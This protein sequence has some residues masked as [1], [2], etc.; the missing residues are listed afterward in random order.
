MEYLS[1][2]SLRN[3]WLRT[4]RNIQIG[5]MVTIQDDNLPAGKW[6]VGRVVEVHPGTDG[7]VRVVTLKTKNGYI[8]RPVVKLS[9]LPIQKEED[10]KQH[11]SEEGVQKGTEITPESKQAD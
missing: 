8:K 6:P 2:L 7:I 5:D 3:K 9:I 10:Y 1:Q 11:S 4:Q